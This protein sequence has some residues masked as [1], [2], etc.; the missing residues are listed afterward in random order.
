[1]SAKT[2]KKKECRCNSCIS[3]RTGKDMKPLRVAI[4]LFGQ[5]RRAAEGFET[6]KKLMNQSYHSNVTFDVFFHTWLGHANP[7][8]KIS[9]TTSLF[10]NLKK[11]DTDVDADV[12]DKLVSMY[13]PKSFDVNTPIEFQKDLYEDTLLYNNTNEYGKENA[14]NNLSQQFSRQRV[15]DLFHSYVRATGTR[16]HFVLGSRFD[17]LN[18]IDINFNILEPAYLHVGAY[19]KPRHSIPDALVISNQQMFL[20]VFNVFNNFP[21]IA[22]NKR[23]AD[24]FVKVSKRELFILHP[25]ELLHINYIYYYKD[26]SLIEYHW[27]IPNFHK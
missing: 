15:R 27:E 14:N 13:K 6:F 24:H 4:C 18:K 2:R 5:P 20:K 17:Y 9:Y 8:G 11:K 16:Y 19:R 21:K 10:R 23:L 12:L 25:E 1:M 3:E 7:G 26:N 22:N